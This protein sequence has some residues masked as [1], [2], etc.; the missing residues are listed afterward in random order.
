MR[1]RD[2][3]LSEFGANVPP[4]QV[5]SMQ[6]ALLMADRIRELE[7]A[8]GEPV[9]HTRYKRVPQE[10]VTAVCVAVDIQ[11]FNYVA[12]I[13]EAFV[14][15]H[16]PPSAAGVT[17]TEAMV[18]AAWKELRVQGIPDGPSLVDCIDREDLRS[19]L[20]AALLPAREVQP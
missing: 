17:V 8:S 13:L 5:V 9:A 14:N 19:A 18:E 11:D 6:T 15:L 4:A 7:A 2:Q 3:V 12:S 1:T 20:T 16:T 10:T